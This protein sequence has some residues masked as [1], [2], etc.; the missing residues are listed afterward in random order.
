MRRY[1]ISAVCGALLLSPL[2]LAAQEFPVNTSKVGLQICPA[3]VANPEG[4]YL[5][6]FGSVTSGLPGGRPG[7]LAQRFG[8]SGERIGA[9][10]TLDA[11]TSFTC[12]VAV[13]AGPGRVLV[14]WGEQSQA[15]VTQQ[16]VRARFVD[17]Q[18][19]PLGPRF[20]I[21][22]GSPYSAPGAAC[23]AEGNCWV[24]WLRQGTTSIRARRFN[25][26]GQPLG[27][28]IRLDSPGDE[29]ERWDIELT[30]D[31][32]GGFIASWWLGNTETGPP[33][34]PLPP[35]NGQIR[36][37]RVSATGVLSEEIAIDPADTTYAYRDGA[38]CPA[39]GGGF[40]AALARVRVDQDA[41]AELLLRRYD[42]SG[43]PTGPARIVAATETPHFIYNSIGNLVLDCGADRLLLT[44]IENE[45]V[46]TSM[47]GRLFNLSGEP[48][49]APFPIAE[50]TGRGTAA[51]GGPD[52]FLAVWQ[53][54]PPSEAYDLVGRTF[55]TTANPLSLHGGR[56]QVEATFRDPR[57]RVLAPANP[58]PLTDDTGLFWFFDDSNLELV[59]KTLDACEVNGHFWVFAAGLTDVEAVITVTDTVSGDWQTYRNPPRT[60]FLPIQDTRAFD[61]P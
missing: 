16:A 51:L 5:V 28:E 25:L 26:S 53:T 27:E 37:R 57:T 24:G 41:P 12:L 29:G 61:C 11:T 42:A 32:Q 13:P 17:F 15:D 19:A 14:V 9:E 55:R 52:R 10:L 34:V 1:L 22:E 20:Q 48:M 30:A 6:L 18:G 47:S 31:G 38:T 36:I 4:G 60:A 56:F 40:F 49:G 44:W 59:V 58:K 3:V 50:P 33:E 45:G 54:A 46:R 43:A 7:V 23:D 21:G 39:P 8:L 35:P 2:S